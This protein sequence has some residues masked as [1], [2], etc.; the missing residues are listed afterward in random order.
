MHE[1]DEVVLSVAGHV[2]DGSF[3]GFGQITAA[4][5]EG[6]LL[7]DLPAIGRGQLVVR[8]ENHQV[9][10]IPSGLKEDQVLAAILVEVARN[11]IIG[12]S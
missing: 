9:Q 5:A 11:H 4:A 12:V 10:V 7:E 1:H 2:C 6:A 8:V 3:A